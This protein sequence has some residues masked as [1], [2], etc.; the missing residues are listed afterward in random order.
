MLNDSADKANAANAEINKGTAAFADNVLTLAGGTTL[1]VAVTILAS[2]IT[3]RLF[4]PEAF[5]LAALFRSASMMLGAIACLRYEM[6]IVLP[7]KDEDAAP[8]FALCCIA[9]V[10]MTIFAAVLQW[11]SETERFFT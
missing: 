4:W 7:K 1:A 9:L 11:S 2:P 10:A 5:G 3:S 6:A 8:L